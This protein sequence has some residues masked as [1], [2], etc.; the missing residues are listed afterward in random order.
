[1]TAIKMLAPQRSNRPG[2]P[3]DSTAPLLLAVTGVWFALVALGAETGFFASI[4]Q[5][6][7][8]VI[9]TAAA[10]KPFFCPRA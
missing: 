3:A 7:I 8:G 9:V 5:P 6:G 2:S 1:M 10:K 4:H